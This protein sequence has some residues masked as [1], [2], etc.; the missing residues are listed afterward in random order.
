MTVTDIK[1]KLMQGNQACAEGAIYAG[2]NFYAGY[3]ITPST[4]I[5]EVLAERMPEEGG[6]FIQMED[7]IAS[8]AAIVGASLTGAKTMTATSGPGFSLKQE[9]FG[10]GIVAETPCVVVNV[11]RLGPSTGGPT[12]PAQGDMMQARWGTHGDHPVIALCP[13]T[14]QECFDL[15]VKAFNLAEEFRTPV[16]LL[17]DEVIGHMRERVFV[18]QPGE[19]EVVDRIK[20]EAGTQNYLAYQP[21]DST[22]VPPMASFGDGYRFHVTGLLHDETGF[23]TN[24]SEVMGSLIERLHQKIERGREKIVIVEEIDIDDADVVIIA[25]GCVARSAQKAQKMARKKGQ[26]VGILR[27]ITVWP[28]P[29]EEV[30]RVAEK[31]KA[32]IVPEMN[33]GQIKDVVQSAVVGKAEVYG[34]GN[35]DGEMVSPCQILAKIE[36]VL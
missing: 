13:S 21:V 19:L 17:L 29:E 12:A 6:K 22:L 4:E 20:P 5:A 2:I 30:L 8:M 23:P 33:R 14:V 3:P 1:A 16:L 7:E 9:N 32:L 36:E 27:L 24:N 31:A 28:F 34:I 35:V 26:K 15:T 11:Q 18:P 25:Y 10:Y